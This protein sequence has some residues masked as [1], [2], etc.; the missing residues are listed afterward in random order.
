MAI[1]ER[2]GQTWWLA[3]GDINGIKGVH[4]NKNPRANDWNEKS[5][6]E[7]AGFDV[8]KSLELKPEKWIEPNE[9]ISITGMAA[10]GDYIVVTTT[11]ST[12][13]KGLGAF[14]GKLNNNDNITWEDWSVAPGNNRALENP[15]SIKAKI[16]TE[17]GKQYYYVALAGTGSWRRQLSSGPPPCLTLAKSNHTFSENAG[18][19]SIAVSTSQSWSVSDNAGWVTATKSGNNVN[20]SVT[21]NNG[22]SPRSAVVTVDGCINRIITITQEAGEEDDVEECTLSTS[23]NSKQFT[24]NGGSSNITVTTTEDFTVSDNRG[25]ISTS[26]SGNSVTITTTAN[27]GAGSRSG[28]VTINGCENAQITVSQEGTP[29]VSQAPYLGENFTIPGKIEAEYYDLGGQGT[30]YN[31]NNQKTGDLTFRPGDNVDVVSK[32]QASNGKSI[33]WSQAGEWVEYTTDVEAGTYDIEFTYSSGGNPGDLRVSLN[34]AEIA[35]FDNIQNTGGWSVFTTLTISDVELSASNNAVLRL[36]Y[37]NGGSFDMDVI[38]FIKQ[39]DDNCTVAVS[40]DALSFVSGL[41]TQTIQVTTSESF[42]SFDNR[43]WLSVTRSGNIVSITANANNSDNPRSGLVTIS[44]CET[45]TISITQAAQN[46]SNPTPTVGGDEDFEGLPALNQWSSGSFVGNDGITWSYTN[47]KRTNNVI[48][49]KAV[50]IDNSSNG[51][52]SASISGGISSLN[53]KAAP[54]GSNQSSGVEVY[55]NG[56]IAQTFAIAAGSGV[57]NFSINNIN[58]SGTVTIEFRGF[59]NSDLQIDDVSWNGLA[60]RFATEQLNSEAPLVAYPN[61]ANEVVNFSGNS[62]IIRVFDIQGGFILSHDLSRSTAM[63][64]SSLKSGMYIIRAGEQILKLKKQ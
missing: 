8:A 9:P 19:T 1:L 55:V 17:N 41:S 44:G 7:F 14:L 64:I 15:T 49:G 40:S 2:N 16:K 52:L 11:V 54:T 21:A 12:H 27:N 30:A 5:S 6:W 63:D 18:S 45:K 10:Q 39:E 22:T 56:N 50:K 28:V 58:E 37:V 26:I 35:L 20:I 29:V 46:T 62:G 59:N 31:D 48:N 43:N 57:N 42:A 53:F 33:G 3:A 36:E 34:G 24:S 25:W 13:K 51:S 61:P 47:I 38:E 4:I 23:A 60:A 32:Q